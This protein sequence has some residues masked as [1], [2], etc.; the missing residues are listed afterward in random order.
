M[1]SRAPRIFFVNRFFHPDLTATS[2]ILSDLAFALAERGLPV[3]V[4]ASRLRND[5]P[6]ALLP[7]REHIRGVEVV[8][9]RTSRFGG[10]ARLRWRLVDYLTFYGPAALALLVRAR[11]GDLIV[12]KTDPP[13]I[14]VFASAVARMR[15]ARLVNWLQDVFP[16][17]AEKSMVGIFLGGRVPLWLKK[18]RDASLQRARVNVVLGDAMRRAIA[19][20]G[21]PQGRIRV[22]ANWVDDRRITP[23]PPEQ[24]ALRKTWGLDG[25]FVV[26]YSGN[27]G[28]VHEFDTII[29][30]A[31]RLARR[32]EFVFLFI[33][34]GKQR[35]VLEGEVEKRGLRNVLFK[36]YQDQDVLRESL[37]ALDVHLVTQ[38]PAVEGLVFPSKLYAALAA[39][40]PVIFIG[41]T[42]GDL[43]RVL[44]E[45][46]CG[47]AFAPGDAEGV[48]G[49]IEQLATDRFLGEALGA[50]GRLLLESRFSRDSA[51]A[52]W[53]ALLREA[54][55]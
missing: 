43:A 27:M 48:A 19:A 13:L 38:K 31:A 32:E 3:T 17:I 52:A 51:I 12:A 22:I 49:A 50:N 4:I 6:G 30:A 16:E 7:R 21:V 9:V 45:G 15:G 55:G 46:G 34:R 28:Q 41:P 53:E 24:S 26:G 36:P 39:A 1:G 42:A 40:R 18:L 37:G 25:K 23:L 29:A 44:H 8:R 33:G 11:R 54:I 47:L 5:V 10:E 35:W 14:S 20:R 2:Q